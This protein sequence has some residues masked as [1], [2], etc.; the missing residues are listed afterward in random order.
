VISLTAAQIAEIV[1]G[2][3]S[4]AADGDVVVSGIARIDSRDLSPGDL[5]IAFF[6]EN[7]DG[8][9]FV[10][11]AFAGG[12]V[13]ALVSRPVSAPHVLVADTTAAASALARFNILAVKPSCTVIAITG[14]SGK[15]STKDLLAAVLETHGSTIAP[16]GS[17]NNEIG[18][19]LTVLR[20]NEST[21]YL[22]LEMGARGLGHL[23]W[24]C[25]IA[26]PDISMVL[27]VGAAHLGE[28]GDLETTAMA[29]GEIVA[30]LSPSGIAVL[31]AD[32]DRVRAMA[33]RTQAR[34]VFFGSDL[35]N[36]AVASNIEIDTEGFAHFDL[37]IQGQS[38]A[39][40]DLKVL[41]RHQI[42]N[43]LAVAAVAA[44][45]GMSAQHIATALSAAGPRSRWRMEVMTNRSGVTVINDAYNAN[46]DSMAVAV[47]AVQDIATTRR[48]GIVLG[49]MLELGE[50]SQQAHQDLGTAVGKAGP[51]W[52]VAVG[53]VGD[54]IAQ[55]IA[56]SGA[57]QVAVHLAD[58]AAA[59]TDVVRE[60][61]QPGD[62]VL[63]KASRGIGLEVVATS[64]L[65]DAQ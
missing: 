22:I 65:G 34:S 56:T 42:S 27:N 37:C 24:L 50:L 48:F 40:V 29:K 5:F 15:T 1:G 4:S 9:D 16:P 26:P 19:P 3:V 13:L 20:A 36:L 30:A 7:V 53:S 59:A 11:Q 18:L 62:V 49:E 60:L 64:L 6:G 12:A 61:V 55:G 8:H 23:E 35:D 54:Q 51:A 46:P 2:T 44:E 63:I 43:A 10:E 33:S 32:D 52:V 21:Q 25:S 31:N 45:S 57:G 14:S 28:F 17:F 39:R 47:Q 41:G 58:D 38:P